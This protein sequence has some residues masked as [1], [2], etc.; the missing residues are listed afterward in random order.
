MIYVAS[1]YS[2]EDPLV[3]HLRYEAVRDF[4]AKAQPMFNDPLYSP[5]VHWHDAAVFNEMPTNAEFWWRHNSQII[6]LC[7]M[8]IVLDIDGVDE[9]KGVIQ[10]VGYALGKGIKVEY[11]NPTQV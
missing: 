11:C 10:E 7:K 6:D 3:R 8:V 2:H 1:P 5:I 9:S 4:V